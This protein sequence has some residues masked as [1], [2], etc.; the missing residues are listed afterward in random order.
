MMSRN[1]KIEYIEDFLKTAS[2][3]E[4]DKMISLV[5]KMETIAVLEKMKRF[6]EGE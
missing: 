4:I 2:V 5:N 3:E 6:Y 1:D